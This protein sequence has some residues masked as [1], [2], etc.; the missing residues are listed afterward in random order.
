MKSWTAVTHG[1]LIGL[2]VTAALAAEVTTPP[3]LIGLVQVKARS[4]DSA[5][6]LPGTDFRPYTKVLI[7]PAEVAFRKDWKREM[8][9]RPGQHIDDADANAIM[10]AARSGFADVWAKAF[11]KAGYEVV[12]TD[13]PDVLRLSPAIS[14]L[15]IN[16]PDTMSAGRSKTYTVEAGEATL[17]LQVRDSQTGATV[18]FAADRRRTRSSGGRMQWTTSVSNR[19]DFEDLFRQWAA[20]CVDA[21]Q[22]LKA[23]SP[24]QPKAK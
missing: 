17:A 12:S 19:A 11:S 21:L 18:G 6:L 14:N 15:Y 2:I 20:I 16:A 22:S 8:N 13:G 10:E 7:D 24:V 3:E 9:S 23:I 1:L 5:Y 4:V